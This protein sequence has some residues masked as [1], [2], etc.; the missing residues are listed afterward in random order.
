MGNLSFTVGKRRRILGLLD[1][2]ELI[3]QE[4]KEV[5]Q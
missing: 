2:Y 1:K 5:W 3:D 4:I